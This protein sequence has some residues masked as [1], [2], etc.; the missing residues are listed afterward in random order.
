MFGTDK[1]RTT[2]YRT[3]ANG[4]IERVHRTLKTLLSKVVDENEKDWVERLPMIA[5]A[6]TAAQH[7]TT[8]FSPY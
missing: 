4:S 8:E 3:S 1:L 5:A 7:E 6:Y 2:A